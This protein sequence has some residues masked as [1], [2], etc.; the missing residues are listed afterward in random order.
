MKSV[1]LVF[2]VLE[3]EAKGATSPDLWKR[4]LSS[5]RLGMVGCHQHSIE[6]ALLTSPNPSS[7]CFL[8]LLFRTDQHDLNEEH[9]GATLD[10]QRR[11]G[12]S[13]QH[14]VLY[15]QHEEVQGTLAA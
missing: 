15:W 1:P 11:K 14:E 8:R 3:A 6:S 12:H 10:Q 13:R 7:A 9:A 2:D 5:E 4:A